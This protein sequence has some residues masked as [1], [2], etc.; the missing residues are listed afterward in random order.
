MRVSKS[1]DDEGLIVAALEAMLERILICGA[2]EPGLGRFEGREFDDHRAIGVRG[3][4]GELRSVHRGVMRT[5]PLDAEAWARES[6]LIGCK[7]AYPPGPHPDNTEAPKLAPEFAHAAY[8]ISG[9]RIVIA[10]HRMA[11]LLAELFPEK[12]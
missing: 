7:S 12:K 6:H 3:A 8:D 4:R 5:E 9:R 2:V 10:G 1:F 11:A